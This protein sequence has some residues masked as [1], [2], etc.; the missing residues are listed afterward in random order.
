MK[1]VLS[2]AQERGRSLIPFQ[3]RDDFYVHFAL[4]QKNQKIKADGDFARILQQRSL[5]LLNS[6]T[7]LARFSLGKTRRLS[8]GTAK[9]Y[10]LF[11]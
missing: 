1:Y 9:L 10:A 4:M 7:P 2:R 3:T 5:F 8:S 11:C 6:Q